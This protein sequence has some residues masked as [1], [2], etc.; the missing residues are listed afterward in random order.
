MPNVAAS[1]SDLTHDIIE[2]SELQAQLVALDLKQSMEKARTTLIL[3][4]AGACVA[5]GTIPV[6]LLALAALL[7]EQLQWSIAG[8]VAT[9]MAVGLLIAGV[10]LGIAYGY[11]KQGLVSMERSR[12]ELRRNISWLKTTLRTRGHTAQPAEHPISF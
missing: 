11:I 5:L 4:V 1:V 8:S 2:L 12:E 7:Y 3:A 10:V 6:A 9:A